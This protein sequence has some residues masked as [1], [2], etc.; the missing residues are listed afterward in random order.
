M[1]PGKGEVLSAAK[2]GVVCAHCTGFKARRGDGDGDGDG[3]VVGDG[4]AAIATEMLPSKSVTSLIVIR[5]FLDW[6][7]EKAENREKGMHET[8]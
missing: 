8:G 3:D 4:L 7:Q 2:S 5:S 6:V 1:L